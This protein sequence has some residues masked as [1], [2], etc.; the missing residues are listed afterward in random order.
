MIEVAMTRQSR[1]IGRLPWA[2]LCER[3][4]GPV[5]Y[6][7]IRQTIV[8]KHRSAMHGQAKPGLKI[9]SQAGFS[10]EKLL[11]KFL[12]PY[13]LVTH[14][15]KGRGNSVADGADFLFLPGLSIQQ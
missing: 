9:P 12:P 3:K 4:L 10:K 2:L 6:I 14:S 1:F 5:K 15:A 11:S 7:A 8:A 13:Q